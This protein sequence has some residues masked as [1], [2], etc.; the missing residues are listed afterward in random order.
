MYPMPSLMYEA[1]LY[2]YYPRTSQFVYKL[3]SFSCST[4]EQYTMNCTLEAMSITIS[5]GFL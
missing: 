3:I 1:E 5:D 2:Q 4:L